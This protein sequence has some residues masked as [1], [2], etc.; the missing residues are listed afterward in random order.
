MS[1][2]RGTTSVEHRY[3]DGDL[4]MVGEYYRPTGPV[5]GLGVLVVHEADG[6]GGNVRRHCAILAG[7]GYAAFAADMHGGGRPL[8]G[9]EMLTALERFRSDP[10]HVRARTRAGLDAF[11]AVSALEIGQIAA[12]GFCFGGFAVLE[13]AR[14]GAPLHAVASFHGLLTTRRAALPGAVVTRVAAFT[15]AKDPLVPP[16]DVAAFQAEMDHARADWLLQVHG[17]A[18]HSFTNQAVDEMGDPRMAYDATAHH[19]S[20]QAML[21]FFNAGI[22]IA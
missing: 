2:V 13:L 20:W 8:A 4:E 6:I 18:K 7:L 12:I 10:D 14:S 9:Q 3:V 5:N 16:Q 15:G 21:A 22:R 17:R 11:A 19:L 1:D